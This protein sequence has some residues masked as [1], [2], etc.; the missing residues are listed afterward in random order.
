MALRIAL[1]SQ[2]TM[3]ATLWLTGLSFPSLW[4]QPLISCPYKNL[5]QQSL[6]SGNDIVLKCD[7]PRALWY[8][9]SILGE[10]LFLINSMHN[11]K[12]L[13]GGSLQLT[14][15]QPSQSGLYRCQD[16]HNILIVEYEID[17][18]DVTTLH[19]THKALDQQPLQNETLRLGGEVLIF[20]QWEPWQVCNRCG[21]PGERKRL[22]Y[23]Y[24]EE[25]QE[26][27]MSCGLYLR[28][29]NLPHTRLRPEMQVETCLVPCDPAKE[30]DQSY[31]IFDIYQLGTLTNNIWL[32]CP[33][34][35]IYRPVS[36]E[37]NNTPL[38]WQNE[39]SGKNLHSTL[40]I[41]SGGRQLQIFQPAIYRCFVEQEV[42]AQFNPLGALK[43][44]EPQTRENKTQEPVSKTLSIPL[45]LKLLPFVGTVL[46]LGL[47]L[48]KTLSPLSG[49][50]R[51]RTL[52]V[53]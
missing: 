43:P 33:L 24:I 2:S 37:A 22:G 17:F 12:N 11:I 8:F 14:N 27:P 32:N 4:A 40:D 44:K 7:L 51:N 47:L 13:P 23:C 15:P 31:F 19:I 41:P 5:C 35:S 52:L 50:S 42:V 21:V 10:D 18:Q 48:L 45:W 29:E 20:T 30:V 36:W 38:T 26:K 1:L 6:L 49:K 53:K 46:V 25:P 9:S 28:E 3:L 16:N 39:L 34:A